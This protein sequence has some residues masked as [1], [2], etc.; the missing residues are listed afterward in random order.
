MLPAASY[1]ILQWVE[2]LLGFFL[3]WRGGGVG[4]E[5]DGCCRCYLL[6][7]YFPSFQLSRMQFIL[8]N[9]ILLFILL[10]L[11]VYIFDVSL[12][13]SPT[14]STTTSITLR[15]PCKSPVASRIINT[16]SYTYVAFDLIK[17][18]SI[19]FLWALYYYFF[20]LWIFSSGKRYTRPWFGM[21]I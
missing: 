18:L 12:N 19:V 10:C 4:V 9:L 20:S 11:N 17:S 14:H 13:V 15:E 8:V 1:L 5:G 16:V 7:R 2:G 21:E 3:Y 6:S